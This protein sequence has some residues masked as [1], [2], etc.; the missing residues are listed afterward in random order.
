PIYAGLL[1]MLLGLFMV[2]PDA[3]TLLVLAIGYVLV[4]V[5]IRL[6]E[7]FLQGQHGQA[8]RNYKLRVRRLL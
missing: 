8:Y 3:F 6:E 2:S 5:Q 1:A 7:Q 4:Q